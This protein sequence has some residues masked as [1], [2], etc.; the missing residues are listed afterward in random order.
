MNLIKKIRLLSDKTLLADLD[1][2][3]KARQHFV[4]DD[5][6][7]E[8]CFSVIDSSGVANQYFAFKDP[9]HIP[10]LRYKN[11]QQRMTEMDMRIDRETLEAHVDAV[12]EELSGKHGEINLNKVAQVVYALRSRMDI[13]PEPD[14]MYWYAAAHFFTLDETLTDFIFTEQEAKIALWKS[15]ME[16]V[17][18]FLQKPVGELI[19]FGKSSREALA[20]HLRTAT[21]NAAASARIIS[22]MKPDGKP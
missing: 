1:G 15:S 11:W 13:A 19:G 14:L 4:F 8:Y 7:V 2:L 20:A 6:K 10:N 12:M 18:F 5:R 21:L 16:T 9:L 3:R 22:S 17:D